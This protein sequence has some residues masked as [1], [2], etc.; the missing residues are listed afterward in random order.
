MRSS[1]YVYV[2]VCLFVNRALDEISCHYNKPRFAAVVSRVSFSPLLL[3]LLLTSSRLQQRGRSS[4]CRYSLLIP[5]MLT[6]SIA[7]TIRTKTPYKNAIL[8]NKDHQEN[9]SDDK[10]SV[11]ALLSLASNDPVAH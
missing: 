3:L 5:A 7:G 9:L 6:V 2:C 8:D 10:V 1:V 4:R 11:V